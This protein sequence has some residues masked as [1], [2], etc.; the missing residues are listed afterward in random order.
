MFI[1][2]WVGHFVQNHPV[3]NSIKCIAE[4]QEVY[5]TWLPLI[6]LR[7]SV[8]YINCAYLPVVCSW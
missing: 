4:I 2:L 6:V 5:I 8:W 1:Q 7:N 3:R